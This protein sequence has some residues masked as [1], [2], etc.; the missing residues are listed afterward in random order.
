ML[1]KVSAA[2]SVIALFTVFAAANV[3][4]ATLGPSLRTKLN[5][6]AADAQVGTVIIAFNT[7]QGLQPAHLDVL[8]GLGITGGLTLNRLGMVAAV[9][10]AGQVRALGSNPAVRSVWFNDRLSYFD[11]E[12]RTL[13]GVERLRTDRGFTTR[14]GGLPVSGKGDFSIV[15]NDSGID[16]THPDMQLGRN[17]I[18]NVQILTGTG[19]LSG[20][21]TLQVVENLPDTDLNLSLIHI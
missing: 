21:T 11:A 3:S 8:R 5:S 7:T 14:N 10:T 1:R 9:A 15:I 19:T 18:Q 6:L 2:F 12:A 17:V 4:A 16:A 13:T 20:F